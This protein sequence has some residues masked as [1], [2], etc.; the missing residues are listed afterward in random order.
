MVKIKNQFDR[1]EFERLEIINFLT[2]AKPSIQGNY[3]EM[4]VK[5]GRP[6]CH[7]VNEPIHLV[8]R[9]GV[10]VKKENLPVNL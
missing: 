5:Y 6:N 4:L 7:C 1:L 10:R 8:A 2:S 3:S 9:P